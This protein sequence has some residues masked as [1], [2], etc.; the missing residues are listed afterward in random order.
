MRL[1]SN[2][3]LEEIQ[4]IE[5]DANIAGTQDHGAPATAPQGQ[6]PEN[7]RKRKFREIMSS[8]VWQHFKRNPVQ[9][10][11][12]YDP[13]CNYCGQV[14]QMRNQKDTGSLKH[15]FT[16]ACKKRPNKYK[17]DKLQRLL[18]SGSAVGKD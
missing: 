3:T 14:Y 9:T 1:D 8:K 6:A 13:I 11:S 5:I 10:D 4:R 16:K 12:F 7:T 15:H 17:H 2:F 18:Q